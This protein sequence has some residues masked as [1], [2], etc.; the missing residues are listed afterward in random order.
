MVNGGV[1]GA[2]GVGGVP[3]TKS[4][5]CKL[6]AETFPGQYIAQRETF[7]GPYIALR[8]HSLVAPKGPA[9]DGK[10]REML[11]SMNGVGR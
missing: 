10:R 7:R 1:E 11:V 2:G 6:T 3:E 4:A 5:S 8:P 9:D